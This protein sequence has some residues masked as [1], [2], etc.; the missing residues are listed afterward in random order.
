MEYRNLKSV[1]SVTSHKERFVTKRYKREYYYLS[2]QN[3]LYYLKHQC[4]S[5]VRCCKWEGEGMYSINYGG[6]YEKIYF[7]KNVNLEDILKR[8][9]VSSIKDNGLIEFIVNPRVEVA[10]SDK[11]FYFDYDTFDDADKAARTITSGSF[12]NEFKFGYITILR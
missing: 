8:H 2:N 3:E 7:E 10:F 1:I 9:D 11:C 6:C 5:S 4:F 12:L